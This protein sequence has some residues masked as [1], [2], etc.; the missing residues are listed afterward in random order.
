MPPC[1]VL[2]SVDCATA[3]DPAALSQGF[4]AKAACLAMLPANPHAYLV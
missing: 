1:E 4:V 2:G 3:S